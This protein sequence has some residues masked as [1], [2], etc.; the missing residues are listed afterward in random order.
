MNDFKNEKVNSLKF[1][2]LRDGKKNDED[3]VKVATFQLNYK[4][5][6]FCV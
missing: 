6:R 4:R 3:K 5:E 2:I 1:S